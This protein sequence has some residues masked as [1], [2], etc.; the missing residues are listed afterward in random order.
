MERFRFKRVKEALQYLK[1]S[2][3]E[4][5]LILVPVGDEKKI[6]KALSRAGMTMSAHVLPLE[7]IEEGIVTPITGDEAAHILSQYK[8]AVDKAMLVS[9]TDRHGIIT[10]V[11]DHFVR[12]SGYSAEELIGQPH[13]I[14]RH[15]DMPA[16]TFK[17]MWKTILAKKPWQGIIK[18]LNKKGKS[19]YVDAT[20]FPILDSRGEILEFIA[21]RKDITQQMV[22][23]EALKSKERELQ[24]ILDN[25]DAI[26]LYVSKKK[27]ILR[28]NRLFFDYFDF[29]NLKDFK[30]RHDCICDLFLEEEGYI[31]P[32]ARGN[33]LDF[34]SGNPDQRHKVKMK[35]KHGKTRTFLLKATP[36]GKKR[37]VL[38]LNDITPL[39]EALIRAQLNE[40]AKSQFVANMS[41]EIRTPLN[42]ILGFTEL[43]LKKSGDDE[44]RRYLEIIHQSGKTLLGIVNDIL[45]LSKIESGGMKLAPAP[46][47]LTKEIE[48]VATVFAAKAKE[49]HIAYAA[50]IDPTIPP[51]VCDILRIKQVLG[52]LINNA[53]KFTPERGEV[54][55]DVELLSQN[56]KEVTVGFRVQ[57]NGIGIAPDQQ[58]K[59][60]DLFTQADESIHKQFGGT[61]LG[62][63]ISARFVEMMGSKITVTS[64]PGKGSLFGFELR[65]PVAQTEPR[66]LPIPSLQQEAIHFLHPSP[67]DCL[68]FDTIRHYLRV[69]NIPYEEH[70]DIRTLPSTAKLL[71]ISAD[72]MEKE[73][74]TSWH[75]RFPE[76]HIAYVSEEEKAE[77]PASKTVHRLDMPVVGSILFDLIVTVFGS[78]PARREPLAPAPTQSYKGRVLV[79]EDNPVNQLLIGELLKERGIAFTLAE[80]GKEALRLFEREGPFDLILMD[81]NM[82][83]MDGVETAVR[84]LKRGGKTPIVALTANAMADEKARYLQNGFVAHL[85]KPIDTDA[86]EEILSA[87]LKPSRPLMEGIAFDTVSFE[88][89]KRYLGLKNERV[90]ASL[91]ER[92]ARSTDGMIEEL[93]TAVTRNDTSLLKEILHKIKGS[94]GNMRFTHT[95]NKAQAL[96]KRLKET[97]SPLS[98]KE[99]VSI[100][101]AQLWD[102]KEKIALFLDKIET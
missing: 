9:K 69:W 11:N 62:L 36:L 63:P 67:H 43:L 21:L 93:E 35:D 72:H 71:F 55:L 3:E 40:H 97:I 1:H 30:K 34:V 52:N 80:N 73:P 5:H 64:E 17:K 49:K 42:G 74:A 24:A 23:Q 45:D 53:I 41:H 79:A 86:L 92:F 90:L 6:Q 82:P 13:S 65:L 19:Y 47:D 54:E 14:V 44:M 8:E 27:G 2:K 102:L 78:S 84:L 15:P 95:Y 85:T 7:E 18:N 25:L 99:E 38:T 81:V 48:N 4:R 37:F 59:I 50:F 39:E 61:G 70:T 12:C 98:L 16:K 68:V 66:P 88:P 22:D 29:K 94:A 46:A 51:V 31:Y 89:L 83:E 77:L 56:E 32:K 58:T 28:T 33:W 26:T 10:Y 57:D 87:Y 96:E 91:L 100:L 20:I 75:T 101:T 76:L 60:F